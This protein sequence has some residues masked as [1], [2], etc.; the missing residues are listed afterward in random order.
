MSIFDDVKQMVANESGG[1]E[2]MAGHVV[3]MVKDPQTGGLEGMLQQFRQK[4]L[5]DTVDSWVGKEANKAI[6]PEE[7]QK[8]LGQSRIGEIASK[9]GISPQEA[10]QKLAQI[11]PKVIDKLTPGG[12]AAAA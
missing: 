9:F 11:L 7:I 1:D 5:G 12:K 8:V 10:S 6:S 3:N 4:G 2:A